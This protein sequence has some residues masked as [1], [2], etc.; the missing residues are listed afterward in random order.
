MASA[1]TDRCIVLQTRYKS[2]LSQGF[3]Y[4]LG[5]QDLEKAL[6]DLSQAAELH[7]SFYAC[8]PGAH[9]MHF[10]S[11]VKRDLPHQV[12][13]GHFAKWDKRPSM[14]NSTFTDG[15]L[16]GQWSIIVYPVASVRKSLARRLLIDALPSVRE[17]FSRTRPESW[18]YGEKVCEVWFDPLEGR[19]AVNDIVEKS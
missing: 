16:R 11:L 7:V 4:P 12:L 15:Y 14:S 9:N 13:E 17:W 1:I 3:S 18:Y 2:R 10:R 8:P 19:L 5:L 6:G